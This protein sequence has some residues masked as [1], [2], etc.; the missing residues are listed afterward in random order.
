MKKELSEFDK[1]MSKILSRSLAVESYTD[2][3]LEY[4]SFMEEID[5]DIRELRKI[6]DSLNEED[7][8][9]RTN[10]V[11]EKFEKL[12]DK[13]GRE[14]FIFYEDGN[15]EYKWD[16]SLL[17][18]KPIE[19]DKKMHMILSRLSV[20][21]DYVSNTNYNNEEL[22]KLEKKVNNLKEIKG[23]LS[24]KEKIKK[25]NEILNDFECLFNKIGR[26]KFM[27]YEDGDI[28]YVWDNSL[29]EGNLNEK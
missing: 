25:S 11:L 28:E 18:E 15:V 10:K 16:D 27:F 6:K 12:F 29:W 7:K 5:T 24:V 26:E 9:I 23:N 14:K 8:V 13:V 2:N 20:I 3:T 19:F 1:N 22:E 4:T 21:K 17:R